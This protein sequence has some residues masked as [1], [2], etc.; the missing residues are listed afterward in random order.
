MSLFGS[1]G[2]RGVVGKDI[3]A[4]L[5]LRIGAAVGADYQRVLIGKDTRTSGDLL[6]NAL[7]AGL[8]SVGAEVAYAS[9]VST[10]TLARAAKGFNC[11]LMVTASHNPPEYN[12]V[13]MWNPD[14]SAFDTAQMTDVEKRIENRGR[15][16][17]DWTEVGGSTKL[18]GAT[19]AHIESILKSLPG[20][21]TSV[22]LDCGC[23]AASVISPYVLTGM[24]CELVTLNCQP[25]GRFPGRS[26]EPTAESLHDLMAL[27]VSRKAQLGIAHDGDGDRMVAVDSRGRLVNGDKLLALFAHV[28]KKGDIVAPVDASMILDDMVT[29]EV[30]RTRVGDVYVAEALKK[31]GA[32]F[33][34]EP[35]GT[36][37]FPQYTYCP[38]GILAAAMLISL[39]G[40]G[41]LATIVDSLPSY[42]VTRRSHSF[43]P[44]RRKETG[45]RLQRE[46]RAVD[47]EELNE[48]DGFRARFKDG[49][50]LIRLSGTEPK[51]R[52]S[53]EARTEKEL[54]RLVAMAEKVVKRCLA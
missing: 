26:P 10:P 42:P 17:K 24:G 2:I 54:D 18:E 11:G 23:G 5:A 32:K 27:V 4:D 44:E 39:V 8:T 43:A 7:T 14:G 52:L 22:V 47:C 51:L 46:M 41:D 16:R 13:K 20:V 25:D 29:G 50:F 35:S 6:V 19:E 40:D 49:W 36:F 9:L 1:S 38:D 21:N 53:A 33:G 37:I 45:A 3:T 12:G 30:I 28:M 48:L 15:A 31:R 34:G